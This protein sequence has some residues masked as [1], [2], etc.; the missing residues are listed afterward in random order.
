MSQYQRGDYIT[1]QVMRPS[2][3][4]QAVAPY[5]SGAPGVYTPPAR[6][7]GSVFTSPEISE[8]PT[9]G[10]LPHARAKQRLR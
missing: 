7:Y 8:R 3:R 9:Q 2:Q 10:S 1:P 6:E 4:A 5:R